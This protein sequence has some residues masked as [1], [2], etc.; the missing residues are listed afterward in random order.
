MEK[1]SAEFEQAS[2]VINS[3]LPTTLD[4]VERASLEFEVLGQSLNGLTGGLTGGK[5]SKP[6]GGGKPAPKPANGAGQ[7]KAQERSPVEAIQESTANSMRK[8]AQDVS[9]L[10]AALTPAMVAWR[11]RISFITERFEAAATKESDTTKAL[12]LDS[13][14][15]KREAQAWVEEWRQR[16]REVANGTRSS[17]QAVD[18]TLVAAGT[19]LLQSAVEGAAAATQEGRS[20][21][22][23]EGEQRGESAEA[24]AMRELEVRRAAAR[25]VFT[26]LSKAEEAASAAAAASGEL[27]TALQA[28]E[29]HAGGSWWGWNPNGQRPNPEQRP[30][31]GDNQEHDGMAYPSSPFIAAAS[32]RPQSPGS[33]K[34]RK[35]QR[36]DAA[37][38]GSRK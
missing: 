30:E 10:T 25:A 38:S 13:A 5:R 33:D 2:I 35:G 27:E 31:G 12:P 28:A 16:Q 17:D 9:A 24:D 4:S 23:D 6:A 32:E 26:A 15:A 37:T 3:E 34:S 7:E 22:S 20:G 21:R 19:K 29:R 18:S 36:K 1:A 8:V 14:T 11:K